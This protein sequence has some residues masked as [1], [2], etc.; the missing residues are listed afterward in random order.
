LQRQN[1]AKQ[2]VRTAKRSTTL[3]RSKRDRRRLRRRSHAAPAVLRSL[4]AKVS[5][6][7]NTLCCATERAV[8]A[9]DRPRPENVPRTQFSARPQ[10]LCAQAA[11][12]CWRCSGHQ[13][14][15][16]DAVLRP[17]PTKMRS[18]DLGVPQNRQ[19]G[20]ELRARRPL[21]GRLQSQKRP[22]RGPRPSRGRKIQRRHGST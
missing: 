11:P 9:V 4:V 19:R 10:P 12:D 15:G 6:S 17:L 7:S 21:L 1:L 8:G 20:T 14:G 2:R 5:S 18:A 3:S 16:V 13:G 22:R